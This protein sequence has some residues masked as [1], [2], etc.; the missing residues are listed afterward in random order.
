MP[1]QRTNYQ[2]PGPGERGPAG[3]SPDGCGPKDLIGS[4][5]SPNI[6]R[7]RSLTL[8]ISRDWERAAG[9]PQIREGATRQYS[10]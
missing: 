1:R 6:V 7:T 10:D 3:I 5:M 8:L 4:Q 9:T 2:T